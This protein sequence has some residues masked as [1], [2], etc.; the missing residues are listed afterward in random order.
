MLSEVSARVIASGGVSKLSHIQRFVQ[1]KEKFE[2][3]DGVIVGKA[4]YENRVDLSEAIKLAS[5]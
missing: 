5:G 4:L 2:N 3:F 1:I